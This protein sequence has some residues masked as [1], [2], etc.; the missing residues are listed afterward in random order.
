MNN[1]LFSSPIIIVERFLKQFVMD[2]ETGDA[3]LVYMR[4]LAWE[5]RSQRLLLAIIWVAHIFWM[6]RQNSNEPF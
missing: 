4:H 3:P 5:T 1:S 6:P 2:L